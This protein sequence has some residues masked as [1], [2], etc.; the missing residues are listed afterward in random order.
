M[1]SSFVSYRGGPLMRTLNVRQ[2][3]SRRLGIVFGVMAALAV[4]SAVIGAMSTS[5]ESETEAAS[6]GPLSYLS[7]Q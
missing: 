5:G 2:Q 3:T 4:G 6:T 7:E 1:R